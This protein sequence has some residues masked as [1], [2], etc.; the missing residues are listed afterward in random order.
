[1]P[2]ELELL[3]EWSTRL[4]LQDWKIIL[5]TNVDPDDM[6]VEDSEGCVQYEETLKAALI[7]VIDPAKREE[8]DSKETYIYLRD[9][10]F[11]VILVHELLHLKFCL[12]ER[13]DN[14]DHKLQLRLLHQIID[15]MSRALVKAKRGEK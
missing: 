4:G 14:W 13:G 8:K 11:E 9:F 3:D 10:D 2:E 15:D 1:M 5:N 12:L 6:A 7:Q